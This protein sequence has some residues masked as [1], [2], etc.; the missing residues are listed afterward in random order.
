MFTAF[1]FSTGIVALAEMGDKTQLLALLLA[2]RYRRPWPIVAGIFAA[3][4][5]NHALAGAAG[6]WATTLMQPHV[7]RWTLGLSFIVMAGWMMTPDRLE[8]DQ[9][10]RERDAGA[11]LA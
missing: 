7:L 8:D 10:P 4:L 2:A 5:F 11:C 3:T 9:R 1:I 6:A